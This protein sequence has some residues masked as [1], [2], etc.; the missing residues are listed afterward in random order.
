MMFLR[1]HSEG[2]YKRMYQRYQAKSA[3]ALLPLWIQ[4][5]ATFEQFAHVMRLSSMDFIVD[6]F[7][8]SAGIDSDEFLEYA[9]KIAQLEYIG[10]SKITSDPD[11]E[12]LLQFADLWAFIMRRHKEAAERVIKP[13]PAVEELFEK[14]ALDGF[15]R[16]KM[17]NLRAGLYMR[18]PDWLPRAI[19]LQY[20]LARKEIEDLNPGFADQYLLSVDKFLNRAL[21]Q[22]EKGKRVVGYSVLKSSALQNGGDPARCGAP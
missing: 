4:L 21:D 1:E 17:K 3:S 12:P 5:I 7:H 11:N 13:D 10:S 16:E 6:R 19:A 8:G 2:R 20:A 9:R 22:H 18:R 14:V 15:P